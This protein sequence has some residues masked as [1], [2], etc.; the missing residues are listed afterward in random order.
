VTAVTEQP[1]PSGFRRLFEP[2]TIGNFTVRNRI[3]NTSH[4]TGLRDDRDLRY[5]QERA[6]GGVGLMGVHAAHGIYNYAIGPGPY[7]EAPEWD[8]KALS[9]V[10]PDGVAFYDRVVI[11]PLAKRAQVIHAEGAKCFAQVFNLGA[12]RHQRAMSPAFG[13]SDVADPYEAAVPHPLTPAEIEELIE[14]FAQGI[15]RVREAGFDAAEIHGAHGYLVNEF[16]SPYFN[17]RT[18]RWGGTREGRVQIVADIVA[19]A[20]RLVGSDFPI[21]IRIGVDGDGERRGI[22]IDELGELAALITPHVQYISVSGGTYSGLGDGFE[23]AYVSP[24]YR[25][26]AFNAAAAA[27]VKRHSTVPVFV[28]GRIT[29]PSIAESVLAEGVADMVGM[30]RAL[31]ADP[32]LPNKAR[33]GRSLEIRM[34]LGLSECHAIGRHRVPVTCA[35]NAAAAREAEMEITP[36]PVARRVVVV[37]AGPAG[38]EAARI[39]ALRGHE[40]YLCD[41]AREIGGLPRILAS[42]PNRRNLLDHSVYFE[43]VLKSLPITLML[44]NVVT[45]DELMEFAPD[46]VLVATGGRPMVPEVE[47][48]DSARVL[49]GLDVLQGA[50]VE[51]ERAVIV[52]GFDSQ[53]GPPTIAEYL[54]DQGKKITLISQQFDF[55]PGVEDGTRFPLMHRLAAKKVPV[56]L[57]TKLIS[58]EGGDATVQ[59]AFTGELTHMED[60]TVVLACGMVPNDG[61]A[62]DLEGGVAEVHL[63]GDALAPRRI[64]H[65]TVEGA[66]AALRI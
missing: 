33:Q 16:L 60:V 58:V 42:D 30:V 46:V 18:D 47:G 19:A 22:T 54:A 10:T 62:R 45:A 48:I 37:G 28:T 32:E 14:G 6:R 53:L 24:W 61:L 56:R 59:N 38:L 31:I 5:L 41:S 20:R 51:T 7:K 66:R 55:A 9:P 57:A 2:L 27:S 26:P 64:M 25:E 15:R 12:G 29:D 4:G 13:P 44:G 40:V 11:P 52:G 23:G 65:A 36:A 8:E 1:V 3:V 39:S 50:P 43:T 49:Q 35:V 34:C 21:G 17:R 63:L